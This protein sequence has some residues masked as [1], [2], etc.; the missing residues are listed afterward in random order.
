MQHFFQLLLACIETGR[1]NQSVSLSSL[2]IAVGAV[3]AIIG[4]VAYKPT[5]EIVIKLVFGRNHRLNKVEEII[6]NCCMLL[7][8]GITFIVAF[9]WM[10]IIPYYHYGWVV[11]FIGGVISAGYTTISPIMIIVALQTEH[12][13]AKLLAIKSSVG[14]VGAAAGVLLVGIIWDVVSGAF[15]YALLGVC[16]L[17]IVTAVVTIFFAKTLP[18][19]TESQQRQ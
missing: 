3:G 14:S 9:L 6:A 18:T 15:L 11:M 2:L 1:W 4:V 10:D 5:L 13:E 16:M 8:N 7:L 12:L 19:K 17:M